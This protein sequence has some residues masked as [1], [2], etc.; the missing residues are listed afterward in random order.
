MKKDDMM[1][2][3]IDLLIDKAAGLT[4]DEL[5]AGLA[6]PEVVE[7]SE[8]HQRKMKKLFRKGHS[9]IIFKQVLKYSTRVACIFLAILITASIAVFSVQAWRVKV[10]NFI[11]E[12]SQQDSNIHFEGDLP[13]GDSYS[14]ETIELAYIPEG[15][16]VESSNSS[17]Q[18]LKLSFSKENRFFYLVVKPVEWALSINTEDAETERLLINGAEAF[19]SE[20][21]SVH[22]LVWHNDSY[23][24]TLAGNIEKNE[25]ISIA[26]NIKK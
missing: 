4:A 12:F 16:A 25:I 21:N 9:E 2:D 26:E 19:Y 24:F 5:A 20:N 17:D 7:F 13:Q 22:I 23:S 10:L 8:N 11:I 18:D 14:D 15:F 6:E 1:G 3:F